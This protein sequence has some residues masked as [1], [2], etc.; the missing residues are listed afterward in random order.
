M[1]STTVLESTT[2]YPTTTVVEST[3][4]YPSTTVVDSTTDYQSTTVGESTTG[5]QS[6]TLRES[7]TKYQSTAGVHFPSS[8]VL[9]STT[10]EVKTQS[11]ISTITG[12]EKTATKVTENGSDVTSSQIE[13]LF[14]SKYEVNTTSSAAAAAHCYYY[15]Y[16]FSLPS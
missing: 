14:E 1:E 12:L 16:Y 7:T 10:P 11:T 8:D 6:T 9:T 4:E 2:E 3:T 15:Y 5:Y 13:G